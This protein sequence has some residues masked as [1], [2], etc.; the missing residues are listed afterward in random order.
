MPITGAETP[1]AG[2][3]NK[4][5]VKH[6]GGPPYHGGRNNGNKNNNY[7]YNAP[8][9]FL[10]A[11]V[12]LRGKMFEVKR[13]QSEQVANSKIANDLIKVAHNWVFDGTVHIS[14]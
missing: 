9:K 13:T 12:N 7:N 2:G 8:E 4:P 6:E 1:A 10:G 11:D 5:V 3:E 14:M